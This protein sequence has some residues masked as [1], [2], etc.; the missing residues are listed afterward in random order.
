MASPRRSTSALQ[1]WYTHDP[2]RSALVLPVL[3]LSL[4]V[5]ALVMAWPKGSHAPGK[6]DASTQETG[7]PRG[8]GASLAH[9]RETCRSLSRSPQNSLEGALDVSNRY[10][11]TVAVEANPSA[12]GEGA[13]L[14]S[15]LLLTPRLVLTAGHCVCGW[16]KAEAG[17]HQGEA[18]MDRSGC[19][20][21]ATI[22][23]MIYQPRTPGRAPP[24]CMTHAEARSTLTRSFSSC[25]THR[26]SSRLSTRTLPSSSSKSQCRMSRLL[27]GW[28]PPRLGWMSHS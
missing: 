25:A 18:F 15:G 2:M 3:A 11:F 13:Q 20:S 17:G 10:S 27:P 4:L 1:E 6:T 28:R 23:S 7:A 12:T 16:H 22:T 9:W 5:L 24:P 19:T 26:A 8:T 21:F 14:C